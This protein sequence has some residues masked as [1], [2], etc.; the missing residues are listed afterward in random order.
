MADKNFGLKRNLKRLKKIRK[1]FAF[2]HS[3]NFNA[4]TLC[5]GQTQSFKI[6]V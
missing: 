2:F 5:S 1:S 3:L 6:Q 4:F